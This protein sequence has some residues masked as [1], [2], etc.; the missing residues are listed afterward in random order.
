MR[1]ASGNLPTPRKFHAGVAERDRSKR[2]V[3][4]DRELIDSSTKSTNWQNGFLE[5]E[6]E[7]SFPYGRNDC[8]EKT[9]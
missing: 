8:L 5:T 1:V 7:I 2:Y 6:R 4:A 9:V 3:Y